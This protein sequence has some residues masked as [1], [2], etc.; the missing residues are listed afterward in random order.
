MKKKLMKTLSNT[1]DKKP[2]RLKV[3]YFRKK[4]SII[5][6]SQGSKYAN[7]TIKHK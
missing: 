6:V 1:Y 3:I 7:D 2:W 5:E 4:S